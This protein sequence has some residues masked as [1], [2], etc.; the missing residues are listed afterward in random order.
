MF[1]SKKQ[2]TL[3][4]SKIEDYFVNKE[5]LQRYKK[6]MLLSDEIIVLTNNNSGTSINFNL[7]YFGDSQIEFINS[8]FN[9]LIITSNKNESNI[10][11]FTNCSINDG[12]ITGSKNIANLHLEHCSIKKLNASAK[13]ININDLIVDNHN[14]C[15]LKLGNNKTYKVTINN[16]DDKKTPMILNIETH[17][18]EINN[19][20]INLISKCDTIKLNDTIAT[21][22]YVD[23][24][25]NIFLNNSSISPYISNGKTISFPLVI[26]SGN[27][28]IKD[29]HLEIGTLCVQ[30]NSDILPTN[31]TLEISNLLILSSNT[32]ID[33]KNTGDC[34]IISNNIL[35]KKD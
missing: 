30:K 31:T 17:D 26:T 20:N 22:R 4:Y 11:K 10:I 3:T 1:N 23:K 29:L 25:Q 8:S 27:S 21:L 14:L 7:D 24:T 2:K 5:Q 35:R 19:C 13:V 15:G 6:K 16:R 18:L 32:S 12:E 28:K 34:F 9:K 33:T